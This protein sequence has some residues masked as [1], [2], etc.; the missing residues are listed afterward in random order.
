MRW[1]DVWI[2]KKLKFKEHVEIK[3]GKGKGVARNIERLGKGGRGI[4]IGN[5][6]K[7]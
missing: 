1:L 3:I 7:M 4:G 2:D 5:T 6:K